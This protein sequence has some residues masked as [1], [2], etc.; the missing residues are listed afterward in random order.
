M[1][2]N[3]SRNCVSEVAHGGPRVPPFAAFSA[4]APRAFRTAGLS[5][6]CCSVIH[7]KTGAVCDKPQDDNRQ[8]HRWSIRKTTKPPRK[9]FELRKTALA[10]VED[11]RY[12]R[13]LLQDLRTPRLEPSTECMLWAYPIGRTRTTSRCSSGSTSTSPEFSRTIERLTKQTPVSSPHHC[14]LRP[15]EL[16][17]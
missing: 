7:P 2:T 12:Q 5:R 3:A 16:F 4:P 15:N 11:T 6:P 8:S 14:R 13:R 9:R 1:A 17:P 10:M